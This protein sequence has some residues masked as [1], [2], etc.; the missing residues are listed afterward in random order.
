[1]FLK[2]LAFIYLAA[3]LSLAVQSTGLV[4]PNGI[5]PFQ[6]Y[7]KAANN[8][9]GWRARWYFPALFWIS[10]SDAALLSSTIAG[11]ILSVLLFFGLW[12]KA[13]LILLF[14][15]YLSL[16]HAGQIFL[17]FQWDILL[18]E[19]GFLAIFLVDGPTGLVVF[20]FHWLLFRLRFMSG[21]SKLASGDPSWLGFRALDYYFETQPLPH[22][23]AWFAHHLPEWLL[24][25]GVAFTFFA[26]LIVP[27]LFS[28]RGLSA[29]LQQLSL[30]SYSC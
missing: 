21:A 4:G 15:L 25:T 1:M 8:N 2:L 6:D 3:F 28:C 27:F 12:K 20:L 13:T 10:A 17:G 18:L 26:E 19:T 30:S 5:L 16:Y 22:V 23:G 9:L 11:C 14:V 24:K 7:L 29:C